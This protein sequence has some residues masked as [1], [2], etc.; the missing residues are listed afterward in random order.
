MENTISSGEGCFINFI[1]NF[2]HYIPTGSLSII[3]SLVPD[4]DMNRK[5]NIGLKRRLLFD[6]A[7]QMFYTGE[8]TQTRILS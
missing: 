7:R 5:I 6:N 1:S 3:S 4:M 2:L 8:Y